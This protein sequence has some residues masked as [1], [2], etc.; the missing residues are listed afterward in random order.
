MTGNRMNEVMKTLTI[1]TTLFMPISFLSGFFGMNFFMAP[2][3]DYLASTPELFAV[4]MIVFIAT[5]LIMFQW[6]RH[7]GWF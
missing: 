1:I 3:D 4:I 2:P 7:R 5:P 6:M